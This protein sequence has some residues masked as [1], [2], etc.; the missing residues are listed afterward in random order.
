MTTEPEQPSQELN[1]VR[2][3][4]RVVLW[5]AEPLSDQDVG[6][7][8]TELKGAVGWITIDNPTKANT[9]DLALVRAL[10]AA[11]LSAEA[12]DRIRAVVLTA[13]GDRHFC[14]GINLGLVGDPSTLAADQ[15]SRSYTARDCDV[16]KP[17]IAAVTGAVLGAGLGFIS[18]SDVVIAARNA[19]FL[20]PH[21]RLAQIT[22][23]T[24]IRLGRQL[25]ASEF[26]HSLVGAIPMTAERAH[27][28]GLVAEVHPSADE[29][30]TAAGEL[31][32]RMAQHS[33]TAVRNNLA[34]LRKLVWSDGDDPLVAEAMTTQAAHF[35]HPDAVEGLAAFAEKRPGRWV[36]VTSTASGS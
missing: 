8:R 18:G 30:R 28:L 4:R 31:A 2:F 9:L 20:D 23:F 22:G 27:A 19:T 17:V 26:T 13:T 3:Y 21:V 35:S 29:A 24:G 5:R 7:I 14:A 10:R 36:P 32:S 6:R 34:L 12:D 16:T 25:P 11:W 33:P 15:A 1:V